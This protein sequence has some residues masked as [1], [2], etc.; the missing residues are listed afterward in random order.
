[1]QTMP[2]DLSALTPEER[3]Q[4]AE[5]PSVLSTDCV[6]T[7]CLYMRYSSDRQSEQSIEASSGN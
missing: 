7:C 5:N 6:A 3:Q 4:F 1:M 2:I